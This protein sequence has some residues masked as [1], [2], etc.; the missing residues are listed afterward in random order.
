MQGF[1]KFE[2]RFSTEKSVGF[3]APNAI[4]DS[5]VTADSSAPRGCGGGN[6]H[7]NIELSRC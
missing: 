5:A 1:E 2:V 6:P 7:K 4:F 3:S